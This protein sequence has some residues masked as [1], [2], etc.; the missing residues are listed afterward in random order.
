MIKEYNVKK[1]ELDSP[2]YYASLGIINK[3]IEEIEIPEGVTTIP[4]KLFRDC[5]KLKNIKLPTTLTTITAYEFEHCSSLEKIEIPENVKS[6]GTYA[7]SNCVDLKK[8]K[9]PSSLN[10]IGDSA[11]N[12]CPNI[13]DLYITD[14]EKW[15]TLSEKSYLTTKNFYINDVLL[16]DVI[17]PSSISIIP[18][19]I[20]EGSSIETVFVHK[21]ITEIKYD[22]FRKCKNLKTV[23]F[24]EGSSLTKL[25]GYVFEESGLENIELPNSIT[26]I[27][28]YTFC[29]C[30]NLKTVK[31]PESLESVGGKAFYQCFYL[32]SIT[33]I[34]SKVINY[35]AFYRCFTLTNLVLEGVEEIYESAFE[36]CS[37]LISIDLG[38]DLKSIDDNAFAYCT[39]KTITLPASL[40]S[41]GDEIFYRSTWGEGETLTVNYEGTIEQFKNIDKS[42]YWYNGSNIVG[43]VHCSDGDFDIREGIYG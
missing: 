21:D 24:E 13:E 9:L 15:F 16:K 22:A 37:G 41:I 4:N 36:K 10:S 32:E 19:N 6:I 26:Q 25:G 1:V 18:A 29:N 12:G 30:E 33:K 20:F 39:F 40:T 38:K 34:K 27:P 28:N 8:V 31:L 2:S 11:F 42:R 3:T 17:I 14:L 23:S 43:G 5:S 7:F 35:E